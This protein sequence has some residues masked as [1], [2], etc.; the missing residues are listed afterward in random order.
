M[1][2]NEGGLGLLEVS[3]QGKDLQIK[4]IN[5]IINPVEN[6]PFKYFALYWLRHSLATTLPK[7]FMTL[8]DNS[9][10]AAIPSDIPYFY[11]NMLNHIRTVSDLKKTLK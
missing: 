11:K 6:P 9:K 8:I 4:Q 3:T 1:P 10:P 7:Y 5:I 2:N